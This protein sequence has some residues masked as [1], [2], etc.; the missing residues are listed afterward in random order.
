[1]TCILAYHYSVTIVTK[2]QLST[3]D[4]TLDY[5]GKT[6]IKYA[7]PVTIVIY[8][9]FHSTTIDNA[10]QTT[11]AQMLW[12][13]GILIRKWLYFYKNQLFSYSISYILIIIQNFAGSYASMYFFHQISLFSANSFMLY[14]QQYIVKLYAILLYSNIHTVLFNHI[15]IDFTI[16]L[17]E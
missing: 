9:H 6:H 7:I 11:N 14:T 13:G 8:I 16:V 15:P 3:V 2:S 17:T 10:P 4:G 5:F 1:M 12:T